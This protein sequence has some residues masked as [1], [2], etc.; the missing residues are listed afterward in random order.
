MT[1]KSEPLPTFQN[2]LLESENLT[3][4]S[5]VN[6]NQENS[7]SALFLEPETPGTSGPL[8]VEG[9]VTV[10]SKDDVTNGMSGPF[11]EPDTAGSEPALTAESESR[12]IVYETALENEHG[13]NRGF[14]GL[15]MEASDVIVGEPTEVSEISETDSRSVSRTISPQKVLHGP[16]AILDDPITPCTF[17]EKP[18]P[19]PQDREHAHLP[20]LAPEP[21]LETQEEVPVKETV[22]HAEEKKE[23]E[24]LIEEKT[25][26]QK[27]NMPRDESPPR[28]TSSGRPAFEAA[29]E[30]S[31]AE[32]IK[33]F[34]YQIGENGEAENKSSK[35]LFMM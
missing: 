7:N 22:V 24:L 34:G 13:L 2:R 6:A 16:A 15:G 33:S 32:L 18:K 3:S 21:L 17:L 8:D 26:P 25:E 35:K 30:A 23:D 20:P 5:S 10:A 14:E 19:L 12:P 31:R 28:R 1:S 9:D 27:S 29:T 11:L 4:P